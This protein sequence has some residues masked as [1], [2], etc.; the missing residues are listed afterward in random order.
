[1]AIP[2]DGFHHTRTYLAGLLNAAE[3][4][5]R[6]GAAFTFDGD[7]FVGLV[8]R[9]REATDDAVVRAP[10]FGHEIKD[11][12]P[13]A[14]AVAPR[15]SGTICSRWMRSSGVSSIVEGGVSVASQ[16]ENTIASG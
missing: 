14:V 4:I 15:T 13:G 10:S 12:V 2:I 1:M 3:A 6:R 16:T 5:R 8:R 11:P 7:G 9:L